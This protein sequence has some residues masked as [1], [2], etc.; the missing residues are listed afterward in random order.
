MEGKLVRYFKYGKINKYLKLKDKSQYN[1]LDNILTDYVNGKLQKILEKYHFKEINI[2]PLISKKG[3]YLQIE[4]FFHN[5]TV[6][7]GFDENTFDYTIYL[8]GISAEDFAKSIIEKEY[9]YDFDIEIFFEDFYNMLQKDDRLRIFKIEKI[10]DGMK[11]EGKIFINITIVAFALFLLTFV[12]MYQNNKR[13]QD[14]GILSMLLICLLVAIIGLCSWLYSIKYEVV[15]DDKHILLKTLFRKLELNI[16][17]IKKFSYKRYKKPNFYQFILFIKGK[18]ILLYT[19][20][21]AE[22]ENILNKNK[23]EKI[24]K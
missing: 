15:I 11:E 19:R 4:C 16:C 13:I 17:D 20:Y 24:M 9:G 7:I 18:R 1:C 8:P 10:I 22:F 3:N 14:A 6:D 21:K 5:L 12:Y 2:Y 23:I